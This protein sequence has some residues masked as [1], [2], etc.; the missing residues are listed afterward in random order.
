M[1]QR[2]GWWKE[3]STNGAHFT[4]LFCH[5]TMP[6]LSYHHPD[7]SAAINTTERPAAKRLQLTEGS[8]DGWHFL[9]VKYF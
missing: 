4:V 6:T 3:E 8:H 9:A 7:Q 5:I 1:L 2:N